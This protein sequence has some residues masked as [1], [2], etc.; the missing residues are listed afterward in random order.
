MQ[1]TNNLLSLPL[2]SSLAIILAVITKIGIK[3]IGWSLKSFLSITVSRTGYQVAPTLC[4]NLSHTRLNFSQVSGKCSIIYFR[5]VLDEFFDAQYIESDLATSRACLNTL[6]LL[7]AFVWLKV[8]WFHQCRPL[9]CCYVLSQFA[10]LGCSLEIAFIGDRSKPRANV[11]Q[12]LLYT[13]P[14][15]FKRQQTTRQ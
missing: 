11:E 8:V 5:Q 15:S 6:L 14:F 2:S 7:C 9:V 12:P 13:L 4:E 1:R 3:K 10:P